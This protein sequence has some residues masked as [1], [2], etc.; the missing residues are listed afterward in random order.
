MHEDSWK[1]LGDIAKQGWESL[2][3]KVAGWW[4]FDVFT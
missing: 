2:L 3:L 1:G 4:A